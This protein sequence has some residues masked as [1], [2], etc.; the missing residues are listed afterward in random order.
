MSIDPGQER[1]QYG[2][3]NPQFVWM[4]AVAYSRAFGVVKIRANEAAEGL[5][6]LDT[7]RIATAAA[8]GRLLR[9]LRTLCADYGVPFDPG[10]RGELSRE[11]V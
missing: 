10:W 6:S 3:E 9:D 2:S 5:I 7:L 1:P 4:L 11:N 8:E